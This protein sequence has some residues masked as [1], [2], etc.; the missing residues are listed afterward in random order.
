MRPIDRIK[1]GTDL[2]AKYEPGINPGVRKVTC[3]IKWIYGYSKH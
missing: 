2:A 3:R 1:K